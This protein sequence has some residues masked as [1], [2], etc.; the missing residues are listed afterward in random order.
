MRTAEQIAEDSRRL[1]ICAAIEA[2]IA[3]I[4]KKHPGL[5]LL[6]LAEKL[7]ADEGERL[8]QMIDEL[9]IQSQET[10]AVEVER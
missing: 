10:R 4:A 7:P 3:R 1:S 2:K 5:P 6:E 8:L 9:E